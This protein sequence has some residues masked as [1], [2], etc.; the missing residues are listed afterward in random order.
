MT[1]TIRMPTLSPTMEEGTVQKWLKNEG[2]AVSAG[3]VLAEIETD[4]ATMELETDEAG[5]LGR[6]LVSA[7]TVVPVNQP[8]AILLEEG[9]DKAAL[10][11]AVEIK[12]EANAGAGKEKTSPDDSPP[13]PKTAPK[14][15][16]LT[17]PSG[18]NSRVLASPLARRLATTA[19][20]DLASLAGS[21]PRGRI[22]KADVEAALASGAATPAAVARSIPAVAA[23]APEGGHTD[24]PHSSM[25]RTIARRLSESKRTI[26]HWYVTAD[27]QI[28]ELLR[29]RAKL[30]KRLGDKGK[31]SVNDFIVRA[32]A[33]ALVEVPGVNASWTDEAVRLYGSVDVAVAGATEK[34]LITPIIRNADSKGLRLISAETRELA[35]RARDGKLMPEEYQGSTF[36]ISNLGMYGVRE[37]AAIINP[38]EAAILAIGAGEKRPVVTASDEIAITTVMTCTLSSDHRIIDGAL[39]AEFLAAFKRLVE[40]PPAMLL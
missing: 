40:Y 29:V 38:P 12:T 34:G 6:I 39:G 4:K 16:S 23:A 2:D 15:T 3:E 31:I 26:P 7:G 17:S 20:I 33:Q 11:E 18:Q 8:I 36:T 13:P 25:R 1:I 5:I 27:C 21:G 14:Q 9:E 19:G 30:N 24:I 32:V 22:V 35:A 28:D 37:F 10:D